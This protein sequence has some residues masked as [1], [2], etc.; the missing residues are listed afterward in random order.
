MSSG[1]QT[2]KQIKIIKKE[3]RQQN[4][5]FLHF[6]G[7]LKNWPQM[8]PNGARRIFDP[9]NPDLADILGDTD[10][11]FEIYVVLFFGSQI[12]GFLGPKLSR[13]PDFQTPA[14]DKLSDPNLTPLPTHPGIKCV[15]RSPCCDKQDK[16]L[17]ASAMS[18]K[19]RSK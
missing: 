8:A 15:A 12:S 17:P 2:I 14:A 9:T 19:V 7:P 13:F 3:N 11:D 18:K 16:S 1:I 10:F 5:I 4:K 6:S